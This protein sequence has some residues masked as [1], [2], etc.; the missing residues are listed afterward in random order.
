MN[1]D[2]IYEIV[3]QIYLD[4]Q[5]LIARRLMFCTKNT[6]DL[7]NTKFETPVVLESHPTKSFILV[8]RLSKDSVIYWGTG[9]KII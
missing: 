3:K 7:E 8:A 5:A 2:I 6:S 9:K 4:G 1:R